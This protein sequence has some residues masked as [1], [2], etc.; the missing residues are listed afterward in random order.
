[1]P[2]SLSI[3]LPNAIA[4][5]RWRSKTAWRADRVGSHVV[6]TMKHVAVQ[7]SAVNQQ[8]DRTREAALVECSHYSPRPRTDRAQRRDDGLLRCSQCHDTRYLHQVLACWATW[9]SSASSSRGSQRL[10]PSLPRLG[11]M[12]RWYE[13]AHKSLQP[14]AAIE[15]ICAHLG[16]GGR[17]GAGR[18]L[19]P[20]LARSPQPLVIPAAFSY[21]HAPW[22]HI[23]GI[24]YARYCTCRVGEPCAEWDTQQETAVIRVTRMSLLFLLRNT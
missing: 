5:P 23:L 10:A 18:R 9:L 4:W 22:E 3:R 11:A 13:E 8:Y 14:G 21:P 15:S 24:H 12:D 1:M 20:R 6:H 2:R 19:G 7:L 17:T 16:R